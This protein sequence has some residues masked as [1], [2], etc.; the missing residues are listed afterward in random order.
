MHLPHAVEVIEVSA[1]SS[2]CLSCAHSHARM[3]HAQ[4]RTPLLDACCIQANDKQLKSELSNVIEMDIWDRALDLLKPQI[5]GAKTELTK[6]SGQLP[7]YRDT[8]EEAQQ[9][10]AQA[11]EILEAYIQEIER[12]KVRD[13]TR[14]SP[15]HLQCYR[16]SRLTGHC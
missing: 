1:V 13:I 3:T 6:L 4:T 7:G 10:V 15:G 16:E 9:Q 8:V 12:R 14:L 11:E 2:S 5:Q